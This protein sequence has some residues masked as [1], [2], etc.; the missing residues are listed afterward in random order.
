MTYV[1][2]AE[3]IADAG[4]SIDVRGLQRI[5]RGE[6][7][8]DFDDLLALSVAL[9][10]APVDL[11][12]PNIAD[13][14]K[15]YP[16][17]STISAGAAVVRDWIAGIGLLATPAGA[18]PIAEIIRWMPDERAKLVGWKLLARPSAGVLRAT[19]PDV[20]F[21][22]DD[23]GEA[24]QIADSQEAGRWHRENWERRRIGWTELPDGIY[25]T[26]MI[27]WY[28]QNATGAGPPRPFR[29]MVFGGPHDRYKATYATRAQ[30]DAGHARIVRA[31]RD[32]I[33]P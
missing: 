23:D 6:R 25:V 7:R 33:A 29:S 8:V 24:K 3:R 17:T 18:L 31:L 1:R 16:V 27:T 11:M 19:D 13:D 32:G 20:Y 10:V 9:G 2:L 22:L 14:D 5:E 28:D 15:P 30:A 21:V 4:R 26:T 12:V